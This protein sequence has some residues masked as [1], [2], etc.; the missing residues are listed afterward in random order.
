MWFVNLKCLPKS[1]NV[2]I[3]NC[4]RIISGKFKGK[5]LKS[6]KSDNIR[7]TGDKVKQALFTKLQ[8]DIPNAVVLDLFCGTGALG[9][10]ALSRDARFVYFVDKDKRSINLTK[11][12]LKGLG[13]NYK[14]LNCNY[15]I[16]LNKFTE[17]F[18]LILVDP[19]YLSGVYDNVMKI[20]EDKNL[21]SDGGVVV[22]EHLND[23]QINSN[24]EMFDQKRYG[25][26]TLTFFRKK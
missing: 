26:V 20:I 18:D 24:L 1:V 17:K 23:M 4:M 22:C 10:E 11:E 2:V 9:I 15:D 12:N 19:P 25:T 14:I 6:P 5:P 8:F 21:L 3:L 16:A 7:P 13:T